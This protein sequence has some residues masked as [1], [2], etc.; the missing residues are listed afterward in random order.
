MELGLGMVK[1]ARFEKKYKIG[2]GITFFVSFS[3]SSI[4]LNNLYFFNV[5]IIQ[6]TFETSYNTKQWLINISDNRVGLYEFCNLTGSL[7]HRE[8][9]HVQA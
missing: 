7:R 2:Y 8:Q 3:F 4:D 9:S 5:S 1:V 6:S